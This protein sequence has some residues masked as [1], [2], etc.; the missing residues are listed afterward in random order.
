MSVFN[1]QYNIRT[2]DQIK[3]SVKGKK[4]EIKKGCINQ[5]LIEIEPNNCIPEFKNYRCYFL[6]TFWLLNCT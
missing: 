3:K 2:L 6:H 4:A 1:D 5:P